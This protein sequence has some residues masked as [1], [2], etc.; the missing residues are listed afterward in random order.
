MPWTDGWWCCDEAKSPQDPRGRG[1]ATGNLRVQI[2]GSFQRPIV[3][4]Y[5]KECTVRILWRRRYLVG[6]PGGTRVGDS[7]C[8][9]Y[10]V[11]SLLV[12]LAGRTY[13]EVGC[14]GSKR[15][16]VCT[17]LPICTYSMGTRKEIFGAGARHEQ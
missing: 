12:V 17:S 4:I 5:N 11:S 14:A 2:L 16:A 13:E 1:L 7:P 9:I 6:R 3:K 8:S 15:N 10:T